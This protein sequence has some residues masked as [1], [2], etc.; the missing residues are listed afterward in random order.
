MC[1]GMRLKGEKWKVEKALDWNGW[2]GALNLR[3]LVW[4]SQKI[5][6][7]IGNYSKG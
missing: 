3:P 7:N 5:E 2:D 1:T 6:S 4:S